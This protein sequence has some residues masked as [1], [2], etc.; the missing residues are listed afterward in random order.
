MSVLIDEFGLW[1][2]ITFETAGELGSARRIVAEF[3]DDLSDSI[4]RGTPRTNNTLIVYTVS[5]GIQKAWNGIEFCSHEIFVPWTMHPP[6]F[7]RIL[8]HD[9]TKIIGSVGLILADFVE[10]YS[11][12]D[13]LGDDVLNSHHRR[14]DELVGLGSPQS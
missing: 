1:L 12:G 11:I 7:E 9:T 6:H 3:A 10:I 4:F 2:L 13:A 14:F 5:F 8:F